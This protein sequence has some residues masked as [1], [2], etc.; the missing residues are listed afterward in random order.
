GTYQFDFK[1]PSNACNTFPILYCTEGC[2][3]STGFFARRDDGG[4]AESHLRAATFDANCNFVSVDDNCN[5]SC[6]I[7][8]PPDVTVECGQSTLPSATGTATSS[9]GC[10]VTFSDQSTG[11]TCPT[12]QVITRTWSASVNG[13]TPVTCTQKITVVD[14]TPP[15]IGAAGADATI[16]CPAKPQFTP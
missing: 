5:A 3:P 6:T 11:G 14:T 2:N 9:N 12:V 1:M 16:E 7:Q 4:S 13:G 8:C 15:T 10:A